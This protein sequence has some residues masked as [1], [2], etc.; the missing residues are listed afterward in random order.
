MDS[1]P[2]PAKAPAEYRER[3]PLC[4]LFSQEADDDKR[5][6]RAT[7]LPFPSLP[8]AIRNVTSASTES[9]NVTFEENGA[10]RLLREERRLARLGDCAPT[11]YP[12]L[13]GAEK[14]QH[15]SENSVYPK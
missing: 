11:A 10:I 12:R 9:L 8:P 13:G 15:P 3:R 6:P 14:S 2:N 5:Q 1:V 7:T 4:P